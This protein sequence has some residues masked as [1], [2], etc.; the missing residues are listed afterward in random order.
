MIIYSILLG[1]SSALTFIADNVSNDALITSSEIT[2]LETT[3]MQI[4]QLACQKL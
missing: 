2:S 3:S 1:A 4:V